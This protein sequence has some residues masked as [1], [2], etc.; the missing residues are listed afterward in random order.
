M[1]ILD[2]TPEPTPEPT[3]NPQI[4]F[5]TTDIPTFRPIPEPTYRPTLEPNPQTEF[6]TTGG[7]IP[8]FRPIPEETY[9]PTPETNPQTEFPTTGVNIPTFITIPEP[10]YRPTPEPFDNVCCD[11]VYT[12]KWKQR[13]CDDSEC[14][15]IIC[16]LDAFCCWRKWDYSCVVKA[17]AICYGNEIPK[18]CY[19]TSENRQTI[20]CEQ[21]IECEIE[22]CNNDSF[23]CNRYWDGECANQA[24]KICT[25]SNNQE[26]VWTKWG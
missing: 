19:C 26:N 6:P 10:T 23:C 12:S 24:T 22:I 25:Q 7:N 3:P 5:S 17:E 16:E 4:E 18:C 21:D 9:R 1:P 2:T 14:E 11:C 13:G 15:A 8:T 20:G